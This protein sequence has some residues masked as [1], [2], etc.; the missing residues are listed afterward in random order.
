MY[1]IQNVMY[2]FDITFSTIQIQKN[3]IGICR[4]CRKG[5]KEE[6]INLLP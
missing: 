1:N 4:S 6:Q 5:R 2:Q 3:K